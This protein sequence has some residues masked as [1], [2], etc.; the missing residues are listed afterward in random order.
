VKIKNGLSRHFEF[1]RL[2][3]LRKCIY[4]VTKEGQWTFLRDAANVGYKKS[5]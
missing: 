5:L 4:S 2:A 1:L 3:S